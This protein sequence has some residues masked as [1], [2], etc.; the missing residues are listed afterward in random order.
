MRH[1]F[2]WKREG[3]LL[4]GVKTGHQAEPADSLDKQPAK[5]DASLGYDF[6]D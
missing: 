2:A 5:I 4:R 3:L 6:F 1:A